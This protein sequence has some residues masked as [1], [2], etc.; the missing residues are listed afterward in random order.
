MITK[1]IDT[2]PEFLYLI[3]GMFCASQKTLAPQHFA[4]V[5][6]GVDTLW[7]NLAPPA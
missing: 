1:F 2:G 5:V 7:L 4:V 6:R 3:G